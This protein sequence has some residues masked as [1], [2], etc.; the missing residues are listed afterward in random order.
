MYDGMV[1][2][3]NLM[4]LPLYYYRGFEGQRVKDKLR[5]F[6]VSNT[7]YIN[8]QTNLKIMSTWPADVTFFLYGC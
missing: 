8:T 7:E 6:F 1:R 4:L 3:K 2:N 5:I